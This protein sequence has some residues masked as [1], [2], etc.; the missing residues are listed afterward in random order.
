MLLD[1]EVAVLEVQ[2]CLVLVADLQVAVSQLV[3]DINVHQG[4]IEDHLRIDLP[5][6]FLELLHS[7]VDP[8]L[9][10][11]TLALIRLH[12]YEVVNPELVLLVIVDVGDAGVR[13]ILPLLVEPSQ[14]AEAVAGLVKLTLDDQ[15][16]A[17]N[18]QNVQDIVTEFFA[19]L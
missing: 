9:L 2:Q 10:E 14:G 11:E 12:L 15:G 6:D 18:S 5:F 19:K 7:L 4:L 17:L 3:A 16:L 13:V 1:E 8:P